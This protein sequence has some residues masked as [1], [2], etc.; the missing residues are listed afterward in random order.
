MPGAGAIAAGATVVAPPPITIVPG[1]PPGRNSKSDGI[2]A[3]GARTRPAAVRAYPA[4]ALFTSRVE[5]TWVSCRLS[6]RLRSI[7]LPVVNGVV[8][9]KAI[10]IGDGV[11]KARQA[12]V[13]ASGLQA[14]AVVVRGSARQA[15]SEHLG[16]IG[17]RPESVGVR[18]HPLLQIGNRGEAR[19]R[20]GIGSGGDYT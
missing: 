16:A 15:I 2:G 17:S 20:A 8:G 3:A 12:K 13:F 11:V 9:R 10:F 4:V 14:A 1:L 18:Q 7:P 6:V 5:K 19:G